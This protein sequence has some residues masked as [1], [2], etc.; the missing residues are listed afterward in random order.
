MHPEIAEKRNRYHESQM[1]IARDISRNMQ[2]RGR[3]CIASTPRSGSTLL[4]RMLE[5]TGIAG[6]PREYLNPLLMSAW[7]RINSARSIAL[8]GYLAEMESRRTSPNGMFGIK[9]HW[10]H[11]ETLRARKIAERTLDALLL[12]F[13]RFIFIRRK[14]KIAQ[15]VSYYIAESTGVFHSDQQAWLGESGIG[16]PEYLPDRILQNLADIVREERCWAEFFEEHGVD[17]LEVDHDQLV[18]SYA[19]TSARVLDFLGLPSQ[20]IPQPPTQK[21]ST[22][23]GGDFRDRILRTIGARDLS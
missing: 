2:P 11:I 6:S 22:G 17:V 3:Y 1:S 4:S 8:P 18:A 16:E 21:M 20:T 5:E 14:D 23:M 9:I 13:D 19:E 7:A 10:R 15:A 12:R